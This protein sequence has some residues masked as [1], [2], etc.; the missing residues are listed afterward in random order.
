MKCKF[1]FCKSNTVGDSTYCIGHAKIMRKTSTVKGEDEKKP[2]QKFKPKQKARPKRRNKKMNK[3][4]RVL[5]KIVDAF[6]ALPGNRVCAIQSLVCTQQATCV[7]HKAGR[8]GKKL[9]D[10]KYFEPSCSACNGFIEENNQWAMDHGHKVT[11]LTK[12]EK[13][14]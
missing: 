1:P 7:N 14:N 3:A 6:L 2:K 8:T 13:S 9:T 10:I 12:V 4:M 11:R 5:G